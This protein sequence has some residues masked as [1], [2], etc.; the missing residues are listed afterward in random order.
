MK[1]FWAFCITVGLLLSLLGGTPAY[2]VNTIRSSP[3]AIELTAI[4][5]DW[6]YTDT[7]VQIHSVIFIPAALDDRCIIRDGSATGA[8][9]FDSNKA[10]DAYDAKRIQYDGVKFKPFLAVGDGQYGA[11]AR[12]IIIL[13]R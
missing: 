8:V 10:I 11:A 1:R 5:S 6:S 4:D 12:V 13:N 9:F 2:A 7:Y 3:G